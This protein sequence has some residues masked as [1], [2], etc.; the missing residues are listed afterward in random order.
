MFNSC[1]GIT[2]EF[3]RVALNVGNSNLF[4]VRYQLTRTKWTTNH[5]VRDSLFTLLAKVNRTVITCVIC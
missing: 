1:E 3:I 2:H 4:S 5:D